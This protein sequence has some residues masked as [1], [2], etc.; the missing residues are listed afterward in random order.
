VRA[1]EYCRKGT[2]VENDRRG[3][4]RRRGVHRTAEG[5]HQ[6]Y[7]KMESRVA[8]QMRIVLMGCHARVGKDCPFRM[9]TPDIDKEHA[10]VRFAIAGEGTSAHKIEE[11]VVSRLLQGLE[12]A[13][14]L[15]LS[16]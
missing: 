12:A 9:L 2:T 10:A 5:V 11:E 14:E 6:H 1:P 13:L 8:S 4:A 16:S 3:H 15:S 7:R